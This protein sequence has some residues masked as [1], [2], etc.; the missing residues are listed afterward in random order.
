M[1]K[2]LRI[3]GIGII[4][5]TALFFIISLNDSK[6]NSRLE[7]GKNNTLSSTKGKLHGELKTYSFDDAVNEAEL[8]AEIIIEKQIKEIGEPPTPKTL[9]E[10]TVTEIYKGPPNLDKIE[11]LQAGNSK[12][13]F[14]N[15]LF[16]PDEKYILFLKKAVGEEFEGSDVYWIIGEETNTYSV[17]ESDKVVKNALYDEDLK[18]IEE[19][20]PL[21]SNLHRITSQ[22]EEIQVLNKEKFEMKILELVSNQ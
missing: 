20:V 8:I 6:D 3:I 16:S 11:V 1:K 19:D 12:W 2:V 10:A 4:G 9:F 17:V 7:V 5:F 21:L 13:S 22:E 18:S 15:E 14:G